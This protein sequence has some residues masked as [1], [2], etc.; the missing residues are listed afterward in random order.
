MHFF[1]L[2][3]TRAQKASALNL[4]VGRNRVLQGALL[5]LHLRCHTFYGQS[6]MFLLKSLYSF[7]ATS[8]VLDK[9]KDERLFWLL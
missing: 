6:F 9:Q 8:F 3:M 2:F 4:F 5:C 7:S 1:I